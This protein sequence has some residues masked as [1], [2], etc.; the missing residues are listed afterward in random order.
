MACMTDERSMKGKMYKVDETVVSLL[1]ERK[2]RMDRIDKTM[3]VR[4]V[5]GVLTT[6]TCD[7]GIEH[8]TP[9][10]KGH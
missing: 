8:L 1:S 9:S 3:T 2:M 4:L 10:R 7:E 6:L 5:R